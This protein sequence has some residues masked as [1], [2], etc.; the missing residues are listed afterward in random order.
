MT[1][2][3][4]LYI[5]GWC[6]RCNWWEASA[7]RANATNFCNVNNNGNAN[8]NAASNTGIRAPL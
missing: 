7:N 1:I 4:A 3:Y 2:G 8:N 6:S 5:A